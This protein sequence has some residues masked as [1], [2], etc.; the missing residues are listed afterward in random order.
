MIR[1]FIQFRCDG[2]LCAGNSAPVFDISEKTLREAAADL[3]RK[4]WTRKHGG[5]DLCPRCSK[6][7]RK[8]TAA[9]PTL[10][11]PMPESGATKLSPTRAGAAESRRRRP[12][13]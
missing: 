13:C 5:L 1:T 6:R 12:A 9:A 8:R 2:L 7:P 11:P 4:G 10:F 3:R